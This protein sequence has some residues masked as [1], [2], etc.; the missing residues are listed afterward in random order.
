ME[1]DIFVLDSPFSRTRFKTRLKTQTWR[2]QTADEGSVHAVIRSFSDAIENNSLTTLRSLTLPS[3][4]VT[5][6][7]IDLTRYIYMYLSDLVAYISAASGKGDIEGRF[8]PDEPTLGH[9]LQQ[10]Y[11]HQNYHPTATPATPQT[12][13]STQT[14]TPDVASPGK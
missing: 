3:G 9:H 11:T 5:R 14:S 8:Y 2:S 4:S 10:C 12:R 13:P 6:T 7:G 1:I